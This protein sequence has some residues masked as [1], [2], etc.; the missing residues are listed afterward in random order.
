MKVTVKWNHVPGKP[1]VTS[2]ALVTVSYLTQAFWTVHLP[3]IQPS[4]I[5]TPNQ[6]SIKKNSATHF[7]F[8]F[9]PD[10]VEWT[11]HLS[12]AWSSRNRQDV[13]LFIIIIIWFK[14]F[15]DSR[16]DHLFVTLQ[17]LIL[18]GLRLRSALRADSLCLLWSTPGGFLWFLSFPWPKD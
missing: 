16:S 14:M 13:I 3:S 12:C 6:Q 5:I 11:D 17:D 10:E 9:H 8:C 7:D 4:I 2:V 15:W 1:G 18:T